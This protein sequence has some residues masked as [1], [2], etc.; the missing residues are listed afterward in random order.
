MKSLAAL[1]NEL[2]SFLPFIERRRE[3]VSQATVGW[4]LEHSLVALIKMISGTE[5]SNPADY[6][7]EPF[8]TKRFYVLT[9]GRIPRG[10]VKAPEMVKPGEQISRETILPLLEKSRKKVKSFEQLSS[11]HFFTHPFF[12][13]L[14][15]KPARKVIAI[16][17]DHH[18]RIIRDILTH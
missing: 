12:G 15:I 11:D 18:I 7:K 5:H 10:Q 17:T 8:N 6:K 13:D 9:L 4:H 16:H 1:L 2:E 14:R 3:A